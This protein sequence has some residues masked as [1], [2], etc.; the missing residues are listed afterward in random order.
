M[1][2]VGGMVVGGG[3]FP[4]SGLS[5]QFAQ[6]F[7]GVA[8]VG[9][10]IERLI[11][12]GEGV[13]VVHQVDLHAADVD[14]AFALRLVGL[15]GGDN[16]GA[17]FV[18]MIGAFDVDAPRPG[19]DLSL[20][21][22]PAAFDAADRRHQLVRNTGADFC[23]AD[24]LPALHSRR[25]GWASRCGKPSGACRDWRAQRADEQAVRRQPG[26]RAC[27]NCAAGRADVGMRRERENT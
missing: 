17:G 4:G 26:D 10:G 2:R 20:G 23:C 12:G 13:R 27:A 9:C 15:D 5:E 24:R 16:F 8:G 25:G 6:V 1:F 21:V 7:G 19:V 14:G 18:N 3:L 11:E 22:S